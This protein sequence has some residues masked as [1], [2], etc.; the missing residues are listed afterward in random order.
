M[1]K[2]VGKKKHL[3]GVHFDGKQ[4]WSW[5][6]YD[7]KAWAGFFWL[8][9]GQGA[10]CYGYVN[11]S[12]V[13]HKTQGTCL[14]EEPFPPHKGLLSST[15]STPRSYLRI[16]RLCDTQL[17]VVCKKRIISPRGQLSTWRQCNS[18]REP[19]LRAHGLWIHACLPSVL[20]SY[21]STAV[22]NTA[23]KLKS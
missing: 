3:K 4:N 2:P 20:Q 8:T 14:A 23:S 17:T 9:T 1:G 10:S 7:E 15:E 13:F 16:W 18:F 12:P 19:R 5:K 6:K 11:G 22:L 21:S